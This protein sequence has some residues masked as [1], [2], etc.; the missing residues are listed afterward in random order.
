MKQAEIKTG[1]TYL[2]YHT[3]VEHRKFMVGKLV[4][5]VGRRGGGKKYPSLP[6]YS[7]QNP[8]KR[9][10]RFK[11]ENGQY[12]NAGELRKEIVND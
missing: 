5:V 2:F 6:N 4:K 11:L 12:A 10:I 8:G 1:E 9:P 7:M 3:C